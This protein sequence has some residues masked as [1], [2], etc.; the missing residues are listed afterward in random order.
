MRPPGIA[1]P[2]AMGLFAFA[3]TTFLLS[4]Y[5]VNT[6]GITTPNVVLGMAVFGGGLVQLLA[7]MFEYPRG[8]MFGATVFSLYGAFWMSYSLIFFPGTGIIAAY[9]DPQELNNAV[10]VY[11]IV[12]FMMTFM[13]T[14]VVVKR[15]I[16]LTV[17]LS[18]LSLA[19]ILLAA[20]SFT[21]STKVTKAGGAVG[22]ITGMI[23]FYLGLA[24]LYAAEANP[25]IRLPLGVIGQ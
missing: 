12:W 23:A 24:E 8:N 7:G 14:T 25:I 11:L 19:F 21:A 20:G 6:R 16:G 13:F 22:I 5:N 1:N 17:L 18:V 15:H 10:G 3:S 9:A 4:M 2:A